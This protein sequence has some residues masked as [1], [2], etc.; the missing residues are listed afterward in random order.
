MNKKMFYVAIVTLLIDHICKSII[1]IIF[2]YGTSFRVIQKFF[3]ITP[4]HNPGVAWGLFSNRLIIIILITVLLG[5]I[6][7]RFIFTFKQNKRNIWAF[8]LLIGGMTGNLL[9]R[10]LFGYVRDFLDFRFWSYK[11]PIFNIADSAIV[12]GVG[13]LIIA[14]IKGEDR[15]NEVSSR[16][17]KWKIR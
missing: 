16:R 6:I 14:I 3:Y 11:Y 1:E 4:Y 12:I 15:N 8:G 7:Y 13:L 10:I 5:L 17:N 9:D 2:D